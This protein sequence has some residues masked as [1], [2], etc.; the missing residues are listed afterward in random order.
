[1]GSEMCIRDSLHRGTGVFEGLAENFRAT[2]YHSLMVDG[3]SIPEEVQVTAET[4]DGVIMG[5]QHRQFPIHGV[6]FHPESIASQ[7]GHPLLENFLRIAGVAI[8]PETPRG[9]QPA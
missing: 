8:T 2:R 1:M 4:E 5:L 7:L 9:P 3:E 6:Q